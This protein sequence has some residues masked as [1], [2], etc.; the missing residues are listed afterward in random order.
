MECPKYSIME[1]EMSAKGI[2]AKVQDGESGDIMKNLERVMDVKLELVVRIGEISMNLKD[3]LN[4]H[5]GSILEVE[6][7]ADEPLELQIGGKVLVKGEVVT[8][9][10][11]LG[12]RVIKK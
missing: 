9:G 3:V 11:S 7:M 12:L 2:V 8:V 1:L 10:E 5:P 4:L 6:R